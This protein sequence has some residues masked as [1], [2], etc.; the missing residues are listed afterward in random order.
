MDAVRALLFLISSYLV[1]AVAQHD[2]SISFGFNG[3]VR[4]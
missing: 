1:I 4:C 2:G 3:G